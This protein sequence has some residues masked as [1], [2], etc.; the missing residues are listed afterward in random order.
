VRC[1][2]HLLRPDEACDITMA[3]KAKGK[4]G[5]EFVFVSLCVHAKSVMALSFEPNR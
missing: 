1:T 5:R 4:R 2:P 3:S